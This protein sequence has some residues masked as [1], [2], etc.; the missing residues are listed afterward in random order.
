M[1]AFFLSPTLIDAAKMHDASMSSRPLSDPPQK[2]EI[3]QAVAL[4][5]PKLSVYLSCGAS[6]LKQCEGNLCE[7]AFMWHTW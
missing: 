2:E 7:Y 4:E 5:G 6:M 3:D 1:H